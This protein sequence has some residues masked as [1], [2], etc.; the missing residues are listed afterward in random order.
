MRAHGLLLL[1]LASGVAACRTP[2][3]VENA[4]HDAPPHA[5]AGT[6]TA[7]LVGTSVS[8]DGTGSFDPDGQ[9]ATYTWALASAPSGAATFANPGVAVAAYTVQQPG[10]YVFELT[11]TD[12]AGESD[13][14]TVDFTADA[15]T[16]TVDAGADQTVLWQRTVDLGGSYTVDPSIPATV[17]W[18]L[19]SVPPRSSATLT[20][21]STLTPTFVADTEGTYV[22]RMTVNT[23]YS[24]SSDEVQVVAT[25]PR[26]ML[27]YLILD[28]RYSTALDRFVIAS[29]AAPSLHIL[30]PA[31]GQEDVVPLAIAPNALS[32]TPDGLRAAVAHNGSVSLVNLTTKAVTATYTVPFDIYSIVYGADGRVHCIPKGFNYSPLYTIDTGTGTGSNGANIWGYASG[33][34]HPNHTAMYTATATISPTELSHYDVS[35]SPTRFLRNDPDFNAHTKGGEAWFTANGFSIVTDSGNVFYASDN[36]AVDMTFEASLSSNAYLN[37]AEDSALLSKLAVARTVYDNQGN[38]SD[39]QLTEYNDQSFALVKTTSLPD[40]PYNSVSYRSKGKYLGIR[41]DGSKIYVIAN[42]TTAVN[43]LYPLDP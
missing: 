24:S 3:S 10:A 26:Q 16:I 25:V 11:V 4:T 36:S 39:E 13:K 7:V 32:L 37:W 17:S 43:A 6:G 22:A 20:N 40:T 1:A 41:S 35:V 21:P 5:N 23:Q 29:D 18:T 9:I 42:A 28:A 15:P 33:R 19:V 30:D 14:S 31:S 2:A 34:L 27:N 12:D 38:V 8:L